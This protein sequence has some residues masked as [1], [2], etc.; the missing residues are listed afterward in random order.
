[1]A[2]QTAMAI[3]PKEQAQTPVREEHIFELICRRAYELYEQRG[4][5][6]GNDLQDWLQAEAEVRALLATKEGAKEQFEV[7]PVRKS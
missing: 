6:H 2:A 3:K 7:A 1:M 5:A 4:S